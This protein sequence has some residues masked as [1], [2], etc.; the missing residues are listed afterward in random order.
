MRAIERDTPQL[1]GVLPKSY[2]LF[3]ALQR[4]GVEVRMLVVPRQAHGPTEPRALLRL[5]EANLEWFAAKLLPAKK[6]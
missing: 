6:P 1:A 2:E 5:G 4:Q 3:N